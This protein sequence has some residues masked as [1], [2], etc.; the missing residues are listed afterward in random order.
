MK[1]FQL[2]DIETA[3]E[4]SQ[5]LLKGSVKAF[6]MIPN[7]HAVMAQSP[8][9]LEAYQQLHAL[10][11]NVFSLVEPIASLKPKFKFSRNQQHDDF[12]M[13]KVRKRMYHLPVKTN[14]SGVAGN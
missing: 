7:L 11:Q 2:H 8:A 5:P 6:G 3:P 9:V 4:D 12:R 10:A 13:Q 14:R 1:D